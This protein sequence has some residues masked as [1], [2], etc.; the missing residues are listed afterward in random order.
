MPQQQ[1]NDALDQLVD[2]ELIYRR[3]VAPEAEYTFKHALVQDAAYGTLLREPRRALHARIARALESQFPEIVESRPELLARHCTE[4]GLIEEAAI[5]WG[6]AGRRSLERSAL[7]EAEEQLSRAL[8]QI[9][10]LPSTP[11][12]RGEQIKLQVALI[13]PL[14]HLKGYAAWETKA[15]LER[16][17]QLI[18]QAEALG[19]A[20][21]DALLLPS[22]VH[23]YFTASMV[24]FDG[25]AVRELAMQFLTLAEKQGTTAALMIA[26]GVMGLSLLLTGDILTA[27]AHQDRAISLYDPGQHHALSARFGQDRRVVTLSWRSLAL[28]L[29]G[30]PDT[31]R[32]DSERA[33]KNARGLRQAGSLML[34]LHHTSF[35]LIHCGEYATVNAQLDE[36]DALADKTGASQ[37]KAGSMALRGSLLA[38]MGRAEDT[39]QMITA[40]IDACRSTGTTLW[41]PSLLTSLAKAY[42]Q[43]GQ[44]HDAERCIGEAMTTIETTKECWG[45]AEVH[46]TAGEIVL[47][48]RQPHAVMAEAHFERALAVARAQQARSWELRVATSMARLRRDQ[49]KRT[50]ARDLL[51]PIYGWFTEGFDTPDLKEAKA[52]LEELTA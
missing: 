24:A 17:R 26:H 51:A 9:G 44:I 27:L 16:A 31:A 5:L 3:G 47:M 29:L 32:A 19:E 7:V 10:S 1:L 35:A 45:E 37:W 8:A 20:P 34:A 30:Q 40:G 41:M 6:K 38:S 36:L 46:R 25:D 4:A 18:E 49:G 48:S 21:K 12:L 22:I 23:G 13:T 33:V 52:L 11:P 42:A 2:A 39:I 15:A 14:T 43:C 50:E 28:W